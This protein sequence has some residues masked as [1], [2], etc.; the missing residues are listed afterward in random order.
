MAEQA[1]LATFKSP[2]EA[3]HAAKKL[4]SIGIQTIRIDRVS[5]YP[6]EPTDELV[7]PLTGNL[8]SLGHLTLGT[9]F[10]GRNASVLAA[11]D[12]S[13]SGQ[14]GELVSGED[15]LLTVVCPKDQV[16]KAVRIMKDAG[17]NT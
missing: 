7:N 1:I 13:A 17:G 10:D 6:G 14:S 12:P 4:K 16:E 11:A 5:L 2:E 9:D 15:I 8:P 3:E